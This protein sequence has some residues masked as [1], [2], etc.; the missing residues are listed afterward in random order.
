MLL[1]EMRLFSETLLDKPRAVALT[2]MDLHPDEGALARVRE[3]LEAAGERVFP[4]SAVSGAGL[5]EL[6]HFL[7]GQVAARRAAEAAS[8][9]AGRIGADAP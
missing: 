4:I 6:L 8:R 3:S 2:K 5:P 7:S 9:E 1:R